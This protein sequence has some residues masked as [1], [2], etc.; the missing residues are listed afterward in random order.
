M[1]LFKLFIVC[2]RHLEHD[3][4]PFSPTNHTEYDLLR[5]GKP[6]CSKLPRKQC[7]GKQGNVF[8]VGSPSTSDPMAVKGPVPLE[9]TYEPTISFA[10][11]LSRT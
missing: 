2:C 4:R 5:L 1:Q 11:G 3:T 9:G 10:V 8:S 7:H 6:L